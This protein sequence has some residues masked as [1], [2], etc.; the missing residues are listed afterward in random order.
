MLP[1]LIDTLTG[2]EPVQRRIVLGEQN[3][4]ATDTHVDRRRGHGS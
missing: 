1:E 3:V 2:H 4:K